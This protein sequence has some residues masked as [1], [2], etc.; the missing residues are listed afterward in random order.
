MELLIIVLAL[1]LCWWIGFQEGKKALM[2]EFKNSV[3]IEGDS[4]SD[5]EHTSTSIWPNRISSEYD[6]I[7]LSLNGKK[8]QTMIDEYKWFVSPH[9]ING[10]Y[11]ILWAGLNDILSNYPVE[12][13]YLN[14]QVLWRDAQG[15]GFKVIAFTLHD[16]PNHS[17]EIKKL[18]DL[19]RSN[20]YLYT[21]LIEADKLD[22][23]NSL[24]ADGIHLNTYGS[25]LV[26]KEINR[27]LGEEGER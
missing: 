21:H 27:V 12:Q 7:N 25:S 10:E 17:A 19:I 14:L 4:L 16:A 13:I 18:N 15:D 24:L 23:K 5:P 1:L 22:V 2:P 3:V 8:T 9:K 6:V 11:F 20:K 26:A